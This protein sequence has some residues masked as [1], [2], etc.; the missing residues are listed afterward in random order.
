[1]MA[2]LLRFMS[3]VSSLLCCLLPVA[4]PHASVGARRRVH[5]P[6][7]IHITLTD[8]KERVIIVGDVHGCLHELNS[9]LGACNYS[10]MR[11]TVILVG[12]LVTS[13]C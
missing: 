8:P 1:M 4:K 10:S 3:G 2:D 13:L 7:A 11:D 6:P 9:L 5:L 12:D